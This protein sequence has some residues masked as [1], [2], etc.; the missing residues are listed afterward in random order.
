[1]DSAATQGGV[2]WSAGYSTW[3][4]WPGCEPQQRQCWGVFLQGRKPYGLFKALNEVASGSPSDKTWVLW[5]LTQVVKIF[6]FDIFWVASDTSGTQI[7]FL[8]GKVGVAN[9]VGGKRR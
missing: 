6:F 7:F 2:K 8:S 3:A 4:A 1:M 9:G 5:P